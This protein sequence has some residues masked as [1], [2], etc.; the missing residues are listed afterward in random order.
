MAQ[1]VGQMILVNSAEL[2][3][4]RLLSTKRATNYVGSQKLLQRS[5]KG[6]WIAPVWGAGRGGRNLFDVVDL[7][8]VV[9]RL[10]RGERPPLLECEIRALKARQNK[11]VAKRRKGK[12]GSL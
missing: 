10:K 12:G 4:S 9:E 3:G 6:K 8:Q 1:K 2:E 5:V 11:G 7:D